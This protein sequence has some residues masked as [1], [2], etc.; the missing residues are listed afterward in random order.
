MADIA[1]IRQD[2]FSRAD[3][4]DMLRCLKTLNN[5]QKS[6]EN[7]FL[8]IEYSLDKDLEE[9]KESGFK[10][11]MRGKNPDWEKIRGGVEQHLG[12]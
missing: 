11:F 2:F 12:L 5:P 9:I 8:S 6:T 3:K 10:W 7:M 1:A 4:N